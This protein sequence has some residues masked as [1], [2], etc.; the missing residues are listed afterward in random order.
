MTTW[1]LVPVKDFRRGKSRLAEVLRP[2]DRESLAR[3]LFEHV[4][5]ALDRA[6]EID[7][8]AVVSDSPAARAYADSLGLVALTDPPGPRGLATIVDGALARLEQ[9][10]ATSAVVCMSDLPELRPEDVDRVCASLRA[11]DVVLVPDGAGAGT[12]AIAV[13]P[14]T[15]LPSCLGHA[16]SLERHRELAIEL[17]LSTT[18]LQITR[19]AF[20]LDD[21]TDLVRFRRR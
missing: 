18:V 12:N 7:R 14:P 17:G 19:I 3:E 9:A 21:P 11:S 1:A 20:D 16:D 15:V 6:L 5:D 8:I 2:E 4:V 13:R 10:G